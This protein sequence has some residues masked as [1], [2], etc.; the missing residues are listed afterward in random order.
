MSGRTGR[1]TSR[2]LSLPFP[3]KTQ[4]LSESGQE[5]LRGA[6]AIGDWDRRGSD[7]GG[8]GVRGSAEPVAPTKTGRCRAV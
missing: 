6:Y 8:S 2:W 4:K 5:R 7:K 1:Q 3:A